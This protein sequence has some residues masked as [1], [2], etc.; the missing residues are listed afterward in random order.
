MYPIIEKCPLISSSCTQKGEIRQKRQ[1]K[2]VLY[3]ILAHQFESNLYDSQELQAACKDLCNRA[4]QL[5]KGIILEFKVLEAGFG[6]HLFCPLCKS[7]QIADI[8][9]CELSTA[10]PNVYLEYGLAIGT[11]TLMLPIKKKIDSSPASDLSGIRYLE[12][13]LDS[14]NRVI[15]DRAAAS[16]LAKLTEICLTIRRAQWDPITIPYSGS[17]FEPSRVLLKFRKAHL[18][19]NG[20][21]G[22][23]PARFLNMRAA[24]IQWKH[25]E[26]IGATE[27]N[28][29]KIINEMNSKRT[30]AVLYSEPKWS[31]CILGLSYKVRNDLEIEIVENGTEVGTIG[32][33][34]GHKITVIVEE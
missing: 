29:V 9:I 2:N 17:K 30:Y 21:I 25:L 15:F 22:K 27:G 11:N 13:S 28:K 4:Q 12:W 24:V 7:I 18:E 16:R 26:Q 34:S 6:S 14:D 32:S 19:L 23:V 8:A 1:V 10:N 5:L 3:V 31:Q 33:R 20:P